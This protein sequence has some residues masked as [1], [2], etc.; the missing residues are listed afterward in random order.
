MADEKKIKCVTVSR[1][2]SKGYTIPVSEIG[3]LECELGDDDIG[4]KFELELVEFS[5]TELDALQEFEG[6]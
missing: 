4:T 6:W 2:G 3:L 5:Q 1:D